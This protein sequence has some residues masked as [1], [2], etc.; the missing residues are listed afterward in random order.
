[1]DFIPHEQFDNISEHATDVVCQKPPET[2]RDYPVLRQKNNR[3][4][5][6][7]IAILEEA[8]PDFSIGSVLI[9]PFAEGF[10]D[11]VKV[12]LQLDVSGK[13]LRANR[14]FAVVLE[15]LYD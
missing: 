11:P 4:D 6:H 5:N 2:T 13:P 14:K 1:M 15:Y 8:V 7:L 12:R 3:G 9:V 10:K